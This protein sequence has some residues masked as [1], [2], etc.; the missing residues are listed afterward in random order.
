MRRRRCLRSTLALC[1]FLLPALTHAQDAALDDLKKLLADHPAAGFQ[2]ARELF[3]APAAQQDV[4][5]MP[6]IIRVLRELIWGRKAEAMGQARTL[7]T[8]LVA[9]V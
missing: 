5:G 6:A 2:R 1:L 3:A 9:P 7:Y 8:S 4:P